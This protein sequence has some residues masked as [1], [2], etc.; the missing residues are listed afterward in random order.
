MISNR[1]RAYLDVFFDRWAAT[2]QV[3]QT[4]KH[5]RIFASLWSFSVD[6]T[7]SRAAPWLVDYVQSLHVIGQTTL[8]DLGNIKRDTCNSNL[9]KY[10]DNYISHNFWREIA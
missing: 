2:I 9:N 10:K 8:N 4:N 5:V 6:V 1:S 7:F 3:K